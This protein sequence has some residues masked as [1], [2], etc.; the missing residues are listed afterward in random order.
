MELPIIWDEGRRQANISKHGFDFMDAGRLLNRS[1]RLDVELKKHGQKWTRSFAY[2]FDVLAV[3]TLV[4]PLSERTL[5]VMSFR[6][7][8]EEEKE[9]YHYW[10]EHR[11]HDTH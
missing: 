5:Q 4:H 7:A 1:Y 6:P 3:L 11:P 2:V 9:A 10:L 8:S